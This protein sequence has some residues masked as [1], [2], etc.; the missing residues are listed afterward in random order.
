MVRTS[1]RKIGSRI[2]QLMSYFNIWFQQP[3]SVISWYL[4]VSAKIQKD[5]ATEIASMVQ[6]MQAEIDLQDHLIKGV[7]NIIKDVV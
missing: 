1:S 6:T 7:M 5:F 4:I 3:Y 2:Y